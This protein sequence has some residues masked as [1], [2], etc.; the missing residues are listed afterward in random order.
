MAKQLKAIKCPQCGSTDKTELRTDQ[1]RCNNC[2]TEYFL[3][4]DDININHNIRYENPP[5]G[6]PPVPAKNLKRIVPII[7]GVALL[8][9]WVI[10]AT[11]QS[12]FL[13]GGNTTPSQPR[14]GE[15]FSWYSHEKGAFI[16]PAGK[17]VEVIVGQRSYSHRDG[18]SRKEVYLAFY[19]LETGEELKAAKMTGVSIELFGTDYR[20][21][22]FKN[23]DLYFIIAKSRI[24]K[25]NGAH[26]TATDVTQSMFA[27]HPEMTSGVANA[28]FLYDKY[29]D[30]FNLIANDGINYYYYPAEDGLY[31]KEQKQAAENAL[32]VVQPGEK[33]ITKFTF[34][35]KSS[36]YP[37]EKIQ[38]MRYTQRDPQ[39]GP[40]EEPYFRWTERRTGGSSTTKNQIL[41][42]GKLVRS[43]KDLTPGRQYFDPRVLYGD[44]EVVLI[45]FANTP[46]EK[47]TRSLQCLDANTGAIRFTL[48]LSSDYYLRTTLRYKG[49]FVIDN[50]T[51][52]LLVSKE[53]K[54]LN[55]A[56]I[57]K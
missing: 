15:E 26:L 56:K 51:S 44:E 4:N 41:W 6:T 49:G 43:Y 36:D 27:R 1:F 34:S 50:N 3:D 22:T 2:N 45:F 19:D 46:A 38:L 13:S 48:P 11:I 18:D 57:Y 17:P 37:A 25:V 30:G 28:E 47:A 39:G 14:K 21:A 10:P 32:E 5:A 8:L 23:G 35:S 54:L 20:M 9:F 53:G 24:F 29:G 52:I 7:L 40:D 42:G 33:T 16:S 31:N 55:E 12:V